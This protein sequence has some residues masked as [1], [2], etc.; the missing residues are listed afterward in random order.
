MPKKRSKSQERERKKKYRDNRDQE[1]VFRDQEKERLRMKIRR[2]KEQTGEKEKAIPVWHLD[3]REKNRNRIRNIR[4]RK[5]DGEKEKEKE[6]AR[7][8]MRFIRLK[9]NDEKKEEERK[10]AR[11]R[12]KKLRSLK[13]IEELDYDKIVKRQNQRKIRAA[14]SGKDH[15]L[16]NL[17]AKKGMRLLKEEG[18]IMK[19]TNRESI[20]KWEKQ[21]DNLFD[22]RRYW[23]KIEGHKKELEKRQPDLVTRM[24]EEIRLQKEIER[25]RNDKDNTPSEDDSEDGSECY[26]INTK[27]DKARLDKEDQEEREAM[28]LQKKMK[29]KEMRQKRNELIKKAAAVPLDPLPERE[30]CQYEKIREDIIKE[31][32]EAMAKFNFFDDLENTKKEI[33]LH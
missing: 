22:W 28:V 5:T 13:S 31:R 25:T 14:Y 8:R 20:R 29:Q 24:N 18:R 21:K 16:E 26:T 33:G 27:E 3:E 6:E 11:E 17:K 7:E 12:M 19:L 1:Q 4:A 9:Q 2:K 30:L 10:K 15:L 23:G 32:K